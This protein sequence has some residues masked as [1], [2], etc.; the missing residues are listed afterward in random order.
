MATALAVLTLG[1][2]ACAPQETSSENTTSE[3]E[4]E[5]SASE[6]ADL[7]GEGISV[8]SA[9][10][11]LEERF[12]TEIVNIGLEKLGYEIEP[13]VE[14]DY[15][16]LFLDM[17]NGNITYTPA[18]WSVNQESLFENSGGD[19]ALE[20]AG[21][22]VSDSLQ[23]YMIDKATADEY[24]ITSLDQLADPEIAALFDTDGDGRAN[25]IG[26][27]AAWLCASII[28]HHID[29]Y[30]LRDTVQQ[31]QGRYIAL[32]ADVVT[33]YDQGQP[34]LYYSYTPFWMQNVLK[35]GEDVIWLE[36]PYTSL[37]EGQGDELT[38]ADT[39][40]GDANLGFAVQDQMIVANQ[41]FVDENPAASQFFALIQIPIEDVNAQNQLMQDGE[42]DSEQ[43]RSH[44]EAWVEA[45]QDLFDG[46]I[47]DALAAQ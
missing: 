15:T 8:V 27:D 45:N 37:P 1:V 10:A 42:D 33:N 17:S 14:V 28:E 40:V 19:D 20:R 2:A 6:A 12:Q 3:S 18:H 31:E 11:V 46:W 43:I 32:L 36:V 13:L 47:E 38:D 9:Y 35:D 39:T 41:A 4:T 7:P 21:S 29:E 16:A 30:G 34:V 5:A 22:I 23:G 24:G 26:C 25:L 44:A